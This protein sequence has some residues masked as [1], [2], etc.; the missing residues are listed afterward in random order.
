MSAEQVAAI[1][2]DDLFVRVGSALQRGL[3]S[4]LVRVDAVLRGFGTWPL[5]LGS[6]GWRLL[7]LNWEFNGMKPQQLRL[8]KDRL[9]QGKASE[10]QFWLFSNITQSP[11]IW[12]PSI[13]YLMYCH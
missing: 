10:D 2:T 3:D 9:W 6:V 7:P 13:W 12:L 4:V 5:L 11:I 8:A 1:Q